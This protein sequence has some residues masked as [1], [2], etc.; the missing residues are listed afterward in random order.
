MRVS[1]DHDRD[2]EVR[3]GAAARDI[4]RALGVTEVW[5]G[6]QRLAPDHPAGVP[7]LVHGARL[8]AAARG[9][10]A[11][12]GDV[13]IEAVRGPDAGVRARVDHEGLTVGR[14]RASG[15]AV[16]DPALSAHHF[17]VMP[18]G[19]VRVRDRGSTNG[20]RRTVADGTTTVAAGRSVFIVTGASTDEESTEDVR[21]ARMPWTVLAGSVMSGLVI[22]AITG[23]WWLAALMLVAGAAVMSPAVVARYRRR[24][25]ERRAEPARTPPGRLAIRGRGM[26]PAGYARAVA[27]DRGRRLDGVTYE[28][29]M[30]W[31]EPPT[32]EDRVALVGPR[33]EAPSWAQATVD[34]GEAAVRERAGASTCTRP[35]LSVSAHVADAA[36]RRAA[37]HAP[38]DALPRTV[39]WGDLREAAGTQST[40]PRAVGLARSLTATLGIG[41]DGPVTIDLDRDG[42]HLLVAGTTGS[43]KSVALETLVT[44]LAH[45]YGPADLSIALVDFKG[46]AGLAGCMEL[47]H[48]SATLTD[49]DGPLAQRALTGIAAELDARKAALRDRGLTSW[50]DWEAAGD[51]PCRLLVVIDEYQEVASVAPDFVPDMARLAAQGRSLGLHLVLATQRPAG[52][53]T[54]VVRAN[55][56]TTLALRVVSDAESRDLVGRPDAATIPRDTPGRALL[57]R[58]GGIEEIQTAS[59][60]A[61][62]SP[63][64][65]STGAA[66]PPG[67]PLADL[68]HE[69]W[70]GHPRPAPLWQA[71][72]P[73]RLDAADLHPRPAAPPDRGAT[74]ACLVVALAD[75]PEERRLMP[76]LWRPA[77]GPLV[78]VGSPGSARDAVLASLMREAA[79]HGMTPIRLPQDPREAARTLSLAVDPAHLLIV[80]DAEGALA[81]LAPVDDG[82]AV[83]ALLARGT[84]G[85]PTVLAGGPQASTRLARGAALTAVMA[86]CAPGQAQ[87][88]SVPRDV[89][90]GNVPG[91]AWLVRAE[92]G[93]L[94]QLA[95]ADAA[96]AARCLVR[97]LPRDVGDALHRSGAWGVGGDDAA[98]WAAPGAPVTVVGPAGLRR[99]AIAASIGPHAREADS[100][101][102][103]PHE[104]TLVLQEPTSRLVRMLAPLD[105][106][107]VVDHPPVPGRVAVIAARRA[108]AVQLPS[109]LGIGARLEDQRGAGNHGTHHRGDGPSG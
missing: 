13:T 46:G 39:R 54:P 93:C 99:H 86:P 82:A 21:T 66:V 78:I 22:G 98:A 34:V 109:D 7:P 65:V 20:T 44:S 91:R 26:W 50:H 48:V 1:D 87:A 106:A 19:R 94:V 100:P 41:H 27:L 16:A 101:H 89:N 70:A 56:A 17:S 36:A 96:P 102:L 73:D 30:R 38:A 104:A 83:E 14:D 31:L 12:A 105:H 79:T 49:L 24:R 103:A 108:A 67:T 68:A 32:A 45:D 53:V 58:A 52:A 4:A 85:H 81:R 8:T 9:T 60:D 61:Q 63:A 10:L 29:W 62:R 40:G 51:A 76:V 55:V 88:W 97:P 64:V 18:G 15:L 25:R 23:R 72:L 90:L 71:P 2:Y 11:R 74:E 80:D 92:G 84:L 107:G 47:P 69:S 35:P 43:G 42:P 57:A 33:D 77:S 37:G 3:P 6:D 59:P 75:L 5:C 28:S 95:T